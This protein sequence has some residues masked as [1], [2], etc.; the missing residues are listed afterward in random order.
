MKYRRLGKTELKVSEIGMGTWQITDDP[1]WGKG[2]GEKVSFEN[3][4]RFIDLGGNLIDTAWV[5]G[6]N[7]NEPNK[8]P[9]E[10]LI[11]KFLKQT[12][13]RNK[14]ILTTKIPPINQLWPAPKGSTMES[15]FPKKHIIS[16]VEDSL[17]SLQTDCIDLMMF[18]VWRDEFNQEDEWKSICEKLTKEGKVRFWG[19]SPNYYE[20]AGCIKTL[21]SG[22]ISVVQ[23]IF[24]IF[25]QRPITE[26][27]PTAARLDI[28]I[29]ACAPLDEG[30]LTGN[31]NLN[32]KF[33]EGDFRAQYFA[34]DR[35]RELTQ[36]T[37]RLKKLL[38][39]EA[40]T[41]PEL[42]LR[43]ILN[44]DEVSSVIPGMRSINNINRNIA[45]SD[46]K[47]LSETIINELKKHSWERNF[48]PWST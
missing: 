46:G 4:Q 7:E 39:E 1:E 2:P 22:I 41:L 6:W 3:L 8:H 29:V 19:L 34:G 9:S 24:H 45:L 38:N 28:G 42:A 40:E 47:K 13:Q 43:F 30:G 35:L 25:H 14:V 16:C 21:E 48:Y 17:R 18:H 36:R 26:L 37:L 23:C 15:T 11:G 27:F 20:P 33:D 5:Y 44:F 12:Q 31:I 32:T 10:E